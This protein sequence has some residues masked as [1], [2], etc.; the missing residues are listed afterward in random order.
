MSFTF[1]PLPHTEARDRIAKL[2]LV[3]REVMDGMLP[4]LRAYAFTVTGLD[5]GDQ[6]AK[7]RDL[8]AAVPAGDKTWAKAKKEIAAELSEGLG[9]KEAQRRAELLLRTHVFRSYAATR[10]R[11]L[12][13]QVEVFP[14]WQYKAHGDGNVRPSHA[15]L[16][17]KIFPA[18]HDIWQRIFPPWDWGCRCL[19]VPLTQRSADGILA[20]GK[21][22]AQAAQDANL[23][24][25]QIATPERFSDREA[26]SID[27]AQRLPGGISLNR[28]PTWSDS[29]WSIPGNIQHDWPLIKARYS[30]QAEVLAAF[31]QWASQQEIEPGVTV[32]MWIGEGVATKVAKK[33]VKK[34]VKVATKK[35]A[36]SV[37]SMSAIQAA[38]VALQD[39]HAAA[40]AQS[41][42]K[43]EVRTKLQMGRYNSPEYLAAK[44]EHQEAVAKLEAIREKARAAVEIPQ[45][46]RGTVKIAATASTPKNLT[47]GREIVERFTHADLM[48]SIDVK[49]LRA[50]G[51][52]YHLRG[53]VHVEPTESASVI[54]HEI[55]HA[56]ERQNPT[57][58]QASRDFLA[59]RRQAKEQPIKL[60]TLHPGFG[61]RSF[62]ITIEDNWVKKGGN[63]YS[64]KIY[65]PGVSDTNARNIWKDAL[66]KKPADAFALIDATE[67]LT[68]GIERLQYDPIVFALQDPDYFNFVVSTLQKL[69]P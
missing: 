46:E 45:A 8:I 53:V 5:V 11:T 39:E 26:T 56:T 64:G 40:L 18:G 10:Y 42:Q 20:R 57:A 48:P 63:A 28:T 60:Q 25:T 41:I 52:A 32:S 19:V 23:L 15:A 69:T 2:P 67:L 50:N 6:M 16:N 7:T 1:Q 34:A 51:R 59:S 65:F 62:E 35:V 9:G 17:G 66:K 61:Y 30:D 31:E 49:L 43:S 24:P 21:P 12:M 47:Q 36:S 4:E 14:W 27:K 54:A 44:A 29:P 58:L 33:I 38:V 68:M 3:S 55:T 22:D 13:Q 37:R